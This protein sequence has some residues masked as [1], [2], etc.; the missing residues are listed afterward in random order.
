MFSLKII[1]LSFVFCLWSYFWKM[2]ITEGKKN[3]PVISK[4]WTSVIPEL[5][6]FLSIACCFLK[7][8]PEVFFTKIHSEN[9]FILRD[10]KFL[11]YIFTM[12]SVIWR[13]YLYIS[14]TWQFGGSSTRLL[15]TLGNKLYHLVQCSKGTPVV[16]KVPNSLFPNVLLKI[17]IVHM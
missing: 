17:K 7:I 11:N 6:C 3:Q 16:E 10:L 5:E 8:Q 2:G 1:L 4:L 9:A 12:F 13:N 15:Q 14:P